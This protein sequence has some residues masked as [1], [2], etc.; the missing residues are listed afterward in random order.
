MCQPWRAGPT[1]AQPR[2]SG[3]APGIYGK[4]VGNVKRI[5]DWNVYIYIYVNTG[6]LKEYINISWN[7]GTYYWNIL[8]Y[9]KGIDKEC[10]NE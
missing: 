6:N 5:C 3:D 2:A 8:E 1:A 4:C 9:L 7:I 10:I